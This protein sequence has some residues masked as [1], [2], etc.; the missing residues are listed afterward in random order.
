MAALELGDIGFPLRLTGQFG[1][2]LHITL[3]VKIIYGVHNHE[4]LSVVAKDLHRKDAHF[5]LS[6]RSTASHPS[7]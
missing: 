7:E 2:S 1:K 5:T 4:Q 6:P 3:E